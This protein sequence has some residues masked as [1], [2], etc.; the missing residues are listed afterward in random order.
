MVQAITQATNNTWTGFP[1]L[2]GICTL[3]VIIIAFVDVDKGREDARK[4]CE[5]RKL[6]DVAP[7][8]QATT[9]EA[10]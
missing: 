7:A 5:A 3:A 2:F 10:S 9:S 4:Y 1:F 6:A 8:N